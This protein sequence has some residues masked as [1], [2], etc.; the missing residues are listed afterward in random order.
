MLF[1]IF[2]VLVLVVIL[3]FFNIKQ[4][5]IV[6]H[7]GYKKSYKLA[8]TIRIKNSIRHSSGQAL[9]ISNP[10]KIHIP[11]DKRPYEVNAKEILKAPSI[12]N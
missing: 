1:I 12:S 3:V 8:V 11:Y 9:F 2:V 4:D 10:K 7:K 5:V 6:V